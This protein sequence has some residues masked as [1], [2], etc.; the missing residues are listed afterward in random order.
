M[1]QLGAEAAAAA[2]AAGEW[3]AA[4]V[5]L[6]LRKE[7]RILSTAKPPYFVSIGGVGY[8]SC[9][10]T[11]SVHMQG[12]ILSM[13]AAVRSLALLSEEEALREVELSTE[14]NPVQ[15]DIHQCPFSP[16]CPEHVNRAEQPLLELGIGMSLRALRETP[17]LL[18]GIRGS[19]VSRGGNMGFAF[20]ADGR[21][22]G[23]MEGFIQIRD[24]NAI[25][26]ALAAQGFY[27][28]AVPN[29]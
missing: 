17:R 15:R 8:L 9:T 4:A 22:L 18:L 10:L 2:A 27:F 7:G 1:G 13:D 20:A 26:E 25:K 28:N 3:F 14:W 23:E 19:L 24:P 11:S 21:E 12:L 16:V 5:G 6:R 29:F